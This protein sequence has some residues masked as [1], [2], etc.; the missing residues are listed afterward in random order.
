MAEGK[1]HRQC[2]SNA[3]GWGVCH[4]YPWGLNFPVVYISIKDTKNID[5]IEMEQASLGEG[6]L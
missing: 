6:L 1:E 4:L 5:K 2:D 3:V